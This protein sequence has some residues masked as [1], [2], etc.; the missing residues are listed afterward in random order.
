VPDLGV[1]VPARRPVVRGF[2]SAPRTV[3]IDLDP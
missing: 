1:P 2:S 3:R